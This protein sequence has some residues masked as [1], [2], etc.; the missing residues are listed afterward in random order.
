MIRRSCRFILDV[1]ANY[2]SATKSYAYAYQMARFEARYR[3]AYSCGCLMRP[4]HGSSRGWSYSSRQYFDF[5]EA[6]RGGCWRRVGVA[7][8][9][10]LESR[11]VGAAR[12]VCPR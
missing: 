5:V 10:F 8:I 12:D 4:E 11:V 1:F 7:Q 3:H 6:L 9:Q 2:L